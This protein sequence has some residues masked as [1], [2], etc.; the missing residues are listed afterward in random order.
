MDDEDSNDGSKSEKVVDNALVLPDGVSMS[1]ITITKA[2]DGVGKTPTT[3]VGVTNGGGEKTHTNNNNN[4]NNNTNSN[5]NS[6]SVKTTASATV[7]TVDVDD[8]D[9]LDD[10]PVPPVNGTQGPPPLK[11]IPGN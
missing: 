7:M 8:D 4:N 2:T 1:E 3:A 6:S 9:I 11:S 5:N 10:A